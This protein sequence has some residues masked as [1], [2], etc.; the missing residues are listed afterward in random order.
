VHADGEVQ[1]TVFRKA[2]WAPAGVGVGW[3][4]QAVPF[5]RSARVPALETPTAVQADAAVHAT[6]VRKPPPCA[7]LGVGWVRQRVPFHRSARVPA[8]EPPTAVHADA[9]VQDTPLSAA[10]WDGLG[11][12]W[13]V[14]LVPFHRSA[15]VPAFDVPT[16]VHADADVQDT[17]LR[18][19]P[20][21]GGL[22]V[23]WMVHLVPFH[24]SATG[25]AAPVVVVLAPTAMQDDADVQ[26]TPNR[27]LTAVPE[28]LGV[29][30]MRHEV[31]FHCSARLTPI[32][33]A[34][35]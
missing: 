35:T 27:P 3:M 1:A 9:D 23:G 6:L 8:L 7:G 14:H 2:N 18:K 25:R 26:A 13:M 16:A 4:R 30:R 34:L 12:G 10:P 15:R 24:R 28:G 31:P 33:E 22:G 19:P 5:H 17:P 29:G 21:W 11:V 32:P 20:P